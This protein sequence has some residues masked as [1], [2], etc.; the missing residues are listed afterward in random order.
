MSCLSC[1]QQ[2]DSVTEYS[3]LCWTIGVLVYHFIYSTVYLL[4]SD[5]SFIPPLTLPFGKHKIVFY[6]CESVSVL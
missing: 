4:I 2:S 6:V 3:S 1:V 5:S